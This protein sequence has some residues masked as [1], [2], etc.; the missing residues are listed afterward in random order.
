MMNKKFKK[1]FFYV[2]VFILLVIIG[3]LGYFLYKKNKQAVLVNENLYNCNFYELVDYVQNVEAYLAKS[4]ITMSSTHSAETLTYLWREAN[5]AQAYLSSL[6]IQS[7]ELENTE[8]FLNQVSDYSY[9]LSRQ[10]IRGEKLSDNDLKN[11]EELHKYCL[12][13]SQ[14]LN[15]LLL[16]FQNGNLSW[17]DLLGGKNDNFA[18]AVST[19]FD[20]FSDME[21]NFHEYSGL[22]YDGAFSEH[23][24]NIEPK[25]IKGNEISQEDAIEKV[26]MYLEGCEINEINALDIS[27][28]T[29]IKAFNFFVK[30]KDDINYTIA[31]S[32]IGGLIVYS[33]CNKEVSEE[34]I[35]YDDANQRAIEYLNKI[36][37]YNIKE[38][39]YLNNNGILT[40]NYAN[41]QD[42]I[43]MYADLIK[44]KVALDNG[45]ILGI[46][47]TGYLNNF[48]EREISNNIITEEEAKQNLN[49]NLNIESQSLA[50]IPT[51]YQT[52]ILCYEFKGK[53]EDTDFLVYINAYSGDEEDILVIY[54]IDNGVLTM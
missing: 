48:F 37:F 24:I 13:L 19:D 17:K 40:I 3:I 20:L 41:V 21:D 4:T 38:T 44:V 50:M 31:I 16:D 29:N 27:E 43:V 45:Q 33:N 39:Y 6:P 30:C 54:N 53:I 15:Q 18:Q 23:L 25:A 26:K 32:K 1:Y 9:S 35:T 10:S 28:N 14:E 11:L 49:K 2:V 5:L 52:E 12:G 47:T 8:K 34:K 46:E 36:G 7:Q 42:N 22:I 51:E